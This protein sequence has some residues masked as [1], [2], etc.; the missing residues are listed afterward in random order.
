[1]KTNINK[2]QNYKNS[3]NDIKLS[4]AVLNAIDDY[5]VNVEENLNFEENS[6]KKIEKQLA[7]FFKLSEEDIKKLMEDY[8]EPL[9]MTSVMNK[10]EKYF[11]QEKETKELIGKTNLSVNNVLSDGMKFW[12]NLK[13]A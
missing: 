6:W 11:G 2:L 1:M 9:T 4:L 13:V 7:N 12:N 3:Q 5:K 8:K 10:A